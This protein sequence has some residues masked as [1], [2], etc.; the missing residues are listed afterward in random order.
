MAKGSRHPEIKVIKP[1]DNPLGQGVICEA[2][3]PSV[4]HYASPNG[5]GTGTYADPASLQDALAP[6]AAGDVVYLL[7][8]NY[9]TKV[10]IEG[11]VAIMNLNKYA[12]RA[13]PLPTA[14]DPL[15]IKGYPGGVAR[16]Q[17]D[18]SERCVIIDRRSHYRFANLVIENCLHEAI[19]L[20]IDI[21]GQD[22]SFTN[23][24]ISQVRYFNNSGFLTVHSYQN[25]RIEDSVFHDYETTNGS[26]GNSFF[27][28]FF[29]AS[30]VLVEGNEFY[31][32]GSGLYYKH[33]ESVLGNGGYTRIYRN[34]FH[35]LSEGVAIKSNQNRTEIKGNLILNAAVVIHDEDG[36]QQPFTWDTEITHNTVV[37]G[38]IQL[39]QGSDVYIP[40]VQLGAFEAQ[41][42]KNILLNSDYSIWEYG[43]DS[44]FNAGVGL[45]S[46]H[47]CLFDE[48]QA[49]VVNYFGAAGSWGD[50]GAI[51]DFAQWQN[52]G[53]DL[54]SWLTDPQ[55]GADYI[56]VVGSACER[57]GHAGF[58]CIWAGEHHPEW[59]FCQ[60][61]EL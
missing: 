26:N 48:G 28:K 34:H 52:L 4:C 42:A 11:D 24:E 43:P 7:P 27:L 22:I 35:D 40:G 56:P 31:G 20:G 5:D 33:G 3:A 2:Q 9:Q 46:D 37:S 60:G 16:I 30:D 6:A 13:M 32:A 38:A 15:T 61:F 44:Q 50:L 53:F 45:V 58:N 19:R 55:L 41:V 18:W 29:Q 17:G 47:N 54:N 39:N 25:V 59:V 51:Y 12:L 8:G 14:A 49:Q 57:L 21:P 23:I 1:T 36:T 10:T